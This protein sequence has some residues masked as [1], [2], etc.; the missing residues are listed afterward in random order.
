MAL[1]N[2]GST[3]GVSIGNGESR[4]IGGSDAGRA[5]FSFLPV[6]VAADVLLPGVPAWV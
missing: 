6:V 2:S 3:A 1:R 4:S 5:T